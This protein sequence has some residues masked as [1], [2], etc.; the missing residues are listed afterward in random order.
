MEK[1]IWRDI[2]D[3]KLENK[4]HA[5]AVF[6]NHIEQVKQTVPPDRLL[7]F[8]ARQGWEP[9]CAFLDVPVPADKP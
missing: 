2:F 6:N 8:D 5:I 9:L 3:N 4:A 1:V 7:A